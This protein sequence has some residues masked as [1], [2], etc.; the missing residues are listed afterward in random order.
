MSQG[1]SEVVQRLKACFPK[2]YISYNNEFIADRAA[3]RQYGG[4]CF[5]MKA[6]FTEED[7]T[8]AVIETLSYDCCKSQPYK[9][10]AANADF[11][12]YMI[13]GTN[14]FLGVNFAEA[15]YLLIY[16][17][18]GNRADRQLTLDFVESGYNL[19]ILTASKQ[20]RM[21]SADRLLKTI[22][23]LEYR[24]RTLEQTR[25]G[26]DVLRKLVPKLVAEAEPV[27]IIQATHCVQCRDWSRNTEEQYDYGYCSR[28]KCFKH[29]RGFCDEGRNRKHYEEKEDSK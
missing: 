26:N 23:G 28:Y 19:Q 22:N 8:C 15:E 21:I 2:G 12:S 29:E 4:V 20:E 6:C 18:L 11:R 1:V 25:G 27:R 24:A 13:S 16:T 9:E 5:S 3:N 17:W 7:V 14:S 10:K